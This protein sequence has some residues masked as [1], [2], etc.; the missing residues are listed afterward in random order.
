MKAVRIE[1]AHHLGHHVL[2]RTSMHYR[3]PACSHDAL[4]G[5]KPKRRIGIGEMDFGESLPAGYRCAVSDQRT[6]IDDP[7][8]ATHARATRARKEIDVGGCPARSDREFP[9]RAPADVD[10]PTQARMLL[11]GP[12]ADLVERQSV[13]GI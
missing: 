5:G 6:P 7:R 11:L 1:L 3:A 8:S 2:G 9:A 4:C 10:V 13:C 12:R